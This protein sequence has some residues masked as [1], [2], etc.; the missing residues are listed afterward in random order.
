[1]TTIWRPVV[2]L[3]LAACLAAGACSGR[4]P[5]ASLVP[6]QD[7]EMDAR[8]LAEFYEE[9]QEYVRLRQEA[10]SMVP[11][12]KVGASAEDIGAHQRAIADVIR[13]L[14]GDAERGDIFEP[15]VEQ[16]FRRIIEREVHGPEG[17]EIVK[18]IADGNPKVEGVPKPSNPTQEVKQPIVLK[19]NAFYPDGAPFSSVPPSLLLKVPELPE[20]V[21]YRF[22]GRALILRDTDANVILDF[23]PDIVPDKAIPR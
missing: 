7:V 3:A 8:V 1:M 12:L 15:P 20:Q 14:R 19:V 18:E 2:L 21:R 4:R 23:I 17:H 22:V 9:V 6:E 10:S 16:A 5:E 13:V 11:P